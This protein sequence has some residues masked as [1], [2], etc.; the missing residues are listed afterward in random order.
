MQFITVKTFD[1]SNDAH[2]LKVQLEGNGIECFLFNE[3]T[4][5]LQPHLTGAFGGVQLK[6]KA[7]DVEDAKHILQE[8]KNTPLTTEK[9]ELLTCPN[10]KSTSYRISNKTKIGFWAIFIAALITML[11]VKIKG[12]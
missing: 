7:E 11:P 6:I 5:N 8:I 4:N 12:K 3:N 2:L 10:C 9:G 1:N